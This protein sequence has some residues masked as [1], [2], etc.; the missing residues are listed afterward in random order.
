[1]TTCSAWRAWA[2]LPP[3]NC[4]ASLRSTRFPSTSERGAPWPVGPPKTRRAWPRSTAGGPRQRTWRGSPRR[5]IGCSPSRVEWD[6]LGPGNRPNR[7]GVL[8]VAGPYPL[9][10]PHSPLLT[11]TGPLEIASL[12]R[13]ACGRS[14]RGVFQRLFPA[15]PVLGIYRPRQIIAGPSFRGGVRG[16]VVA[17][18]AGSFLEARVLQTI[19]TVDP[20]LVVARDLLVVVEGRAFRDRLPVRRDLY[21]LTPVVYPG[22]L[23]RD[24]GGLHS[25]E[26]CLHADVLGLVVLVDEQ[27]V[28]PTNPL[29][30]LVVDRVVPVRLFQLPETV[31]ALL[32]AHLSLLL[33]AHVWEWSL[34]PPPH[35]ETRSSER[36]RVLED[37][38]CVRLWGI[39]GVDPGNP[40]A[41]IE[42][43]GDAVRR[44]P[45][46]AQHPESVRRAATLV[47]EEWEVQV[48]LLAEAP[49]RLRGVERD[50]V[51]S[52]IRPLI[53]GHPVP[54]RARLL[55]TAGGVVLRIEVQN[56]LLTLEVPGREPLPTLGDE[57]DVG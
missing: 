18:A 52:Y 40:A 24:E 48:V 8:L 49:V 31:P 19:V 30:V 46:L 37:L 54:E 29:V 57:L 51:D 39:L 33:H 56:S 50:T 26:A 15:L 14:L 21:E 44:L 43:E 17:V 10:H 11:G 1:M 38:V 13:L 9:V 7:P 45:A 4:S 27:V 36:G 20:G 23:H 25:Q 53:V 34:P 42:E 55:R 28:H 32:D 16:V 22:D 47:G 5:Q 41:G 35:P 3:E 6:D 2:Y 12:R